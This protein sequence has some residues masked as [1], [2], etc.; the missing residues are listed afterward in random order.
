MP[1]LTELANDKN[2]R[3]KVSSIEALG[4][5][6]KEIGAEFLNEKIIKLLMDWLNDKVYAVREA[7]MNS[8]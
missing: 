6:A 8:V 5:F 2:W 4:F 7:A 1:A 3:I